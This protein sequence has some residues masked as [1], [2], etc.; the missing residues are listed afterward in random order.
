[1][2]ATWARVSAFRSVDL[3][4]LDRPTRTMCGTPSCGMPSASTALVT[5]RASK[6]FKLVRDRRL[7]ADDRVRRGGRNRRRQ[8]LDQG[9]LQH[10][11]HR[12]DHV[13]GQR[14]E[15][16]L[17]DV[18][19]V[20]L[21]LARD[22]DRL[23][24]R[25]VRREDLFLEAADRQDLA[26]QRDLA[27]HRDVLADRR[28]AE[29]RHQRR[30][31]GDARR[32]SVL[33]DRA[34]GNVDVDVGGAV[35]VLRDVVLVGLRADVAHRRLRRLLHD[36]AELAGQGQLALAGHQR[37]LDGQDLA[38]DFR[39][40][41]ARGDADLVLL[42]GQRLAEARHAEVLG[43]LGRRDL[44]AERLAL[45]DDLARHLAADRR[46]LALEV[47]DARFAGVALDDR[48]ERLVEEHDV[49]L[50][51]ARAFDRLRREELPGDLDLLELG[52]AGELEHF[53]AVAQRLRNRVQHVGRA[54]EHH[55]RQVV[56]DVEIVIE[57]RAVLLRIEH[58]E[59]RRRRI[60]AEVHRHLVDFVEQEH[61]VHRSGLF[62]HLDDLAGEG[63][64]VG[65]AVAADFRLVAHAAER[66][67]H[68]LAVHRAG[69]RL[70]Q[71]GLADSRRAG[72]GEDRRPRL[73]HQRADGEELEDPF[74]DLLEPVVVLV[75]DFFR[76]LE[77]PAFLGLLLPGDGNQPVE[78]IAGDRGFRGHRRHRLEPLQLLDRLL[79]DLF[80][81]LRLF[82]LL[83]QLFDFVALLVLAPQFLLDRLHLLV[84]VVLLL[85]LLH[86]LLDA[87]LDLAIHLELV[88]FGFEQRVDAVEYLYRGDDF[89]QVLLLV[90][91]D[92][93]VGGNR[94]G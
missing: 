55:V 25:A 12:L 81:H 20:L 65:A 86:R 29:R 74:L 56:L 63:A 88:H 41:Q 70:G 16:V 51:E 30:R 36:V 39:P 7:V 37:R 32:R 49:V 72:E 38:A 58:F 5:N 91:A 10:F 76:A 71:R 78:V 57:E 48:G 82:D 61:R 68:E 64:D 89:E 79:L 43:D 28:A 73:L 62:H 1:M 46:D 34:L 77:I 90:D 42:L 85:R 24:A 93:E 94:V 3:P 75:E 54:D 27:G 40:G 18:G 19:Q 45:D 47:P 26:A 35:E 14:V 60:A 67:A 17:R 22:D 6:T 13:D 4:T 21:V 66:Q 2:R 83:L 69:D 33:G 84:E 9:D 8:R 53:H 44:H 50:G 87:R 80:R 11:V 15:D 92:D 52:V 31:E 23:Q 59:Q